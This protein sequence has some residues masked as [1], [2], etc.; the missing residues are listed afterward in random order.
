L[1]DLRRSTWEASPPLYKKG[2]KQADSR[3]SL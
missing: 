2:V 1:A 3:R